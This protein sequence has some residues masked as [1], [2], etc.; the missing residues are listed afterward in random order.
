MPA[1]DIHTKPISRLYIDTRPLTP[2]HSHDRS[3]LPLITT[4]R[5]EQQEAIQK[6]LRPADR[7]MSLASALL[8][9]TFIHRTAQIPW[10]DI[11]ISKTPVPHKRPYWQPP[12]NWTGTGGLEFNVTHQNGIIAI[13]GCATPTLQSQ[14]VSLPLPS[15]A[16]T[17]SETSTG[18][19]P[20]IRLGVD[21]ACVSEKGRTP[22]TITTQAALDEWVDIFGE[23]FSWRCRQDIK[24]FSPSSSTETRD[25]YA[26]RLRR[27]F[28]YWSLKEAFIKMV[29]EGLL[30]SW[31]LELEF[32]GVSSPPAATDSD[33][34][35]D[36]FSWALLSAEERKWTPPELAV[37]STKAVLY[38]ERL[39]DV[40]LEVVAYE[41][42]F[43]VS[44]CIRGVKEESRDG[45][46]R[47][48]QL[49][50]ERDIRPCA[51][52][53]CRCLEQKKMG[54]KGRDERE[55]LGEEDLGRREE[56]VAYP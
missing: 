54:K 13:I 21:V 25:I 5:P 47:W 48:T 26:L 32:D 37:R 9:Y 2:L 28:T 56:E 44:S 50:I 4:L 14:E 29:G 12:S 33:Y 22:T 8:K 7:L 10:S 51:E 52:G 11:T 24:Y 39:E 36:G 53:R 1:S 46:S 23:M 18:R 27:F 49:D 45:G 55:E 31:L 3:F 41:N 35:D 20:Q 17:S 40:K 34:P 42:D 16:P 15:T 19:T 30:A 43:L 6:F 38:G